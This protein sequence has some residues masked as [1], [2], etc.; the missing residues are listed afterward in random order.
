MDAED[1]YNDDERKIKRDEK[2]VECATRTCEVR[3]QHASHRER[4]RIHASCGADEDPL[5]H[6]RVVGVLPVL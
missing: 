4:C 3:V 6:I 5:P 2:A 1:G